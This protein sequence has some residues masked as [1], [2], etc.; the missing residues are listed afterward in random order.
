MPRLILIFVGGH[1]SVCCVYLLRLIRKYKLSLLCFCFQLFISCWQLNI[2]GNYRI[3][4]T[5]LSSSI[6]IDKIN[7]HTVNLAY[8]VSPVSK[9][10]LI[11]FLPWIQDPCAYYEH[12]LFQEYRSMCCRLLFRFEFFKDLYSLNYHATFR[13]WMLKKMEFS[14]Y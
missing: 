2:A 3:W 5:W 13:I 8:N 9:T 4:W 12:Y 1:R 7:A 10:H 11:P 6:F 14:A